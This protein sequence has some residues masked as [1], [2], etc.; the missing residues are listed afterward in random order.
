MDYNSNPHLP[1]PN[2]DDY[3]FED[4]IHTAHISNDPFGVNAFSG[5]N[6]NIDFTSDLNTSSAMESFSSPPWFCQLSAENSGEAI[7]SLTISTAFQ[8]SSDD[9]DRP[10]PDIILISSD[11]VVFYVAQ[12][13]LL[14]ASDNSFGGLLPVTSEYNIERVRYLPKVQS[15]ELNVMLHII[16]AANCA[17]FCPSLQVIIRAI[18]LLPEYGTPPNTWI[19]TTNPIYDLLL[20]HVPIYPL[21]IYSLCGRHDIYELAI[22]VSPHLLSFDLSS[23]TDEDAE[24]MGSLYLIRLF[25]LHRS[26]VEALVTSLMPAPDLHD[27]TRD[28]GFES[29][30]KILL[31]AWTMAVAYLSQCAKPNI[32]MSDIRSVFDSM[33]THITCEDCLKGRDDRVNKIVLNWTLVKVSP[34]RS[35]SVSHSNLNF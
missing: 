23:L 21:D 5:Y 12:A 35:Q 11:S 26:R 7:Q 13:A 31:S 18:D 9:P 2:P 6:T 10:T 1:A 24:S 16:Y 3:R 34:R 20:L 22:A 29:Q 4:W 15:S 27:P 25:R 33:T 32:T 8:E 28:C 14:S 19:T 17:R 30:Q